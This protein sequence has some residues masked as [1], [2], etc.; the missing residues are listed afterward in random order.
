[1]KLYITALL[2][3]MNNAYSRNTSQG[4]FKALK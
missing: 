3:A 1:M 4:I 2:T